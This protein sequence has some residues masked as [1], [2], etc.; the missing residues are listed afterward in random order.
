MNLNFKKVIL[1]E[2]ADFVRGLTYTKKDEV[3][4][5]DNVVLRANNIDITTNKLDF[6]ALKYIDNDINVPFS[7]IV[8][9]NERDD[10]YQKIKEQLLAG[11]QVYIICPRIDEPDP[12]KLLALNVKSVKEEAL[13]LKKEVFPEYEI[14]I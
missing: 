4:F 11:R 3:E 8:K 10:A 12:T 9:K 1:D 6:T 13:R 7:K 14:R 2:V 5:S